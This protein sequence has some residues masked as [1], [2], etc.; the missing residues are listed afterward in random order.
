M[1]SSYYTVLTF[2]LLLPLGAA[3]LKPGDVIPEFSAKDQHEQEFTWKPG[4]RFLLVSFDM[5][6]GKAANQALAAEGA[7]FL[8]SKKAVFVSNIHGMPGIGRVF[9]LRKMRKYPHRIILA[10]QE[11]LLA[12]YPAQKDCVTVL[13]LDSTGVIESIIFW[14][15]AK[16]DLESTLNKASSK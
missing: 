4:P 8:D 3:E 2:L 5:S 13:S 15:P 10:D 16:E 6:T 12:P 14:K 7:D 11:N 9:A 1:K